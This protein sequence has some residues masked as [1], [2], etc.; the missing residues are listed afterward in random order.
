MRRNGKPRAS[1]FYLAHLDDAQRMFFVTLLLSQVRGWLRRQRGAATLRA[2]LY[3]DE[4]F[5]YCPPYP[6]NPPSKVP[7]LALIKQARAMGLGVVLA[8]QNPVDLDYKG[9]ANIGAWF[10]GRLRTE[11]DKARVL[12]GLESAAT[13]SGSGIDRDEIEQ[14]AGQSA[15]ARVCAFRRARRAAHRVQEPPGDELLA[16]AADA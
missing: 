16:R 4:I 2:M 9:L 15:A 14:A 3:F 12:D 11:R 10:V 7:L 13:E 6:K 8:T 5:G 1:I